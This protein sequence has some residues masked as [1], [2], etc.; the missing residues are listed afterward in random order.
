MERVQVLIVGAGPTGLAA[1]TTLAKLGVAVRI[2]DK[3]SARSDRSKA[4]GVQAGT[5]ACLEN[6]LSPDLAQRMIDAGRPAPEAWIHLDDRP[7]IRIDFQA[8][9]GRHRFILILAQGET[10]RIL[11]E[12]L[13]RRSAR[14]ERNTE[15][16]GLE[17][18]GEQVVSRVRL[19]SGEVEEVSSD[20]VIGCDGAHSA[21]RHQ[22]QIPFKGGA[23]TGDFVLGD[24]ELAWPWP[25]ESIR[26][27]V[28]RRGV[29]ASFPMRGE[30]RY[31]LILIPAKT[32]AASD[33]PDIDIGE[34]RSVV[35][36]LSGGQIAVAAATWLTRFRVHHRMVERFQEGRVFLAGDAA[37][38]H[39][40]AGGQGMNTGIQDAL[41]LAFKLARVLRV[42]QPIGSLRSYGQERL[43]VARQV[44]RGTDLV[45]RLALLPETRPVAWIR[46]TVLPPIVGSAWVQRRVVAAISEMA[47]A[48][49]EIARYPG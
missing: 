28:S 27:F 47:V 49:R 13:N 2:L 37:H 43:P 38:I 26:T 29:I 16:L 48:K 45:F 4:L 34:F 30:R 10:E 5:L 33:R 11:E 46:R 9:P 8:I 23:Y 41:N 36:E 42:D 24:V 15:L 35:S 25:Y 17:D 18:R 6:A 3:N 19:P 44:L 22:L 39:S 21:V 40:P 1:A 32:G 20:F 7:P 12:E 14:V 31:R